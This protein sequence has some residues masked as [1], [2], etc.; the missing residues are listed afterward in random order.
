MEPD[1]AGVSYQGAGF[2]CS[3]AQTAHMKISLLGH[4]GKG[5]Q[6]NEGTFESVLYHVRRL[7]PDAESLCICTGPD[8]VAADYG[9]ATVQMMG[10]TG[11]PSN[12]R[13][14]VA[15][16]LRRVFVGIPREIR[17]WLDAVRTLR[18]TDALV[19]P[20]TGLL[21]DAYGLSHWGPYNLFRW[22][23]AAKLRRSRLLFV[24]VGVGPV[25]TRA[26]RL[27]LRS[28]LSLANYRSFRDEP[29][30]EWARRVGVRVDADSVV[31]DLVFSYPEELSVEREAVRRNRRTVGL[32]LM[33]DAGKYSVDVPTDEIY[34]AY[35]E[36][37][38]AFARWLLDNN[39]NI[40]L[41]IGDVV[42]IPVIHEFQGLLKK[43]GAYDESHVAYQ[44]PRSVQHLMEQLAGTEIVVATRFHNVLMA[45]LLNK[46]AIA[47]SFHHKCSSLMNQMGM[48]NYC[49]DITHLDSAELIEKFRQLEKSAETVKQAVRLKVQECRNS[50]NEQYRLIKN[51]VV[52]AN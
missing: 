18:G 7:M 34:R 9:I 51:L 50:L 46:P 42:D 8:A 12:P 16:V 32:G 25:Y 19:I 26:G 37:M 2:V 39:W 24:S 11:A 20:G 14:P 21:T 45:L 22:C 4:F 30:K 36:N 33:H 29:S 38:A 6:G 48:L 23:L 15:R 47:I 35:L 31:P 41:L 49:Q 13:N 28:A 3:N 43:T 5:N 27:L 17:R 1:L 52:R 10:F 40:R 44:T